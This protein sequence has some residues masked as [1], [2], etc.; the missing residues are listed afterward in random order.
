MAASSAAMPDVTIL[1]IEDDDRMRMSI[2][3]L[4]RAAGMKC[5][6]HSSAEEALADGASEDAAC[7]IC[8]MK[9][10]GKSGLDLLTEL[11]ARNVKAPLIL[12]TAH[13]SP[14]LRDEA[15]RRCAAYLTKPFLGTALLDAVRAAIGSAMPL[16]GGSWSPVP[17]KQ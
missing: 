15:G 11:R 13:D 2:A 16:S 6:E 9:L 14:R 5:A 1:V 7:V 12:I 17:S 4:L 8:D 3:R 10:P